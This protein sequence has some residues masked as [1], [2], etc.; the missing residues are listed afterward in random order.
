M[1]QCIFLLFMLILVLSL[2]A[3]DGVRFNARGQSV[4]GVSVGHR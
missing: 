3:C 4:T 2:A 1:R